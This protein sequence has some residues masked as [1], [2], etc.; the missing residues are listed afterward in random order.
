VNESEGSFEFSFRKSISNLI[1]C[2]EKKLIKKY[3][4]IIEIKLS[5]QEI[6]SSTFRKRILKER[7]SY[8]KLKWNDSKV[9]CDERK[10]SKYFS[11]FLSPK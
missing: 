2:F 1:N 7:E 3:S 4:I 10:E 8:P 6:F 5:N 11:D 9:N